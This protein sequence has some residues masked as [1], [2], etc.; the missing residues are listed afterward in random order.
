MFRRR[1]AP[2]AFGVAVVLLAR[3]SCAKHDRTTATFAFDFGSAAAS[4]Q[5]VDVDVYE[6]GE[7][8]S[9]F[10]RDALP[11]HTIGPTRFSGTLPEASGELHVAVTLPSGVRM[12]TKP[13]HADDGSTVMVSL[14]RDLR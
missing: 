14:E 3:Q 4:V 7:P 1:V 9:H 12:I 10:H 5:A 11:G 6:G 8:F 2:I 13:F